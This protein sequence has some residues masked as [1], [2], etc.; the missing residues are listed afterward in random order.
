MQDVPGEEFDEIEGPNSPDHYN[1]IS[2]LLT[3]LEPLSGNAVAENEGMPESR[4]IVRTNSFR[5]SVRN[6]LNQNQALSIPLESPLSYAFR[7]EDVY[8]HSRERS[9]QGTPASRTRALSPLPLART[10]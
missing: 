4:E 9:W 3:L 2:D 8:L 5:N 10:S 6:L 7:A 1:L